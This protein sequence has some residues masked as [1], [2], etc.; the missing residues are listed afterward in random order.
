[1]ILLINDMKK[2]LFIF[3]PIFQ[4]LLEV[5]CINKT[6]RQNPREKI[7]H[8]WW[9]GWKYTQEQAIQYIEN[10]T[11]SFYVTVGWKSVNVVVAKSRF[12]NKYIK[13]ES[14]GD[15]PNNLLSLLECK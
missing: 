15:M 14:D 10:K 3:S 13:T 11:Y 6:D 5:K 2:R 12:G 9:S 7:S 4:M 1:M 8:I